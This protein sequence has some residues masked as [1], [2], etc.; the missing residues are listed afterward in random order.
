MGEKWPVS[1]QPPPTILPLAPSLFVLR[2]RTGPPSIPETEVK[3][4]HGPLDISYD[5]TLGCVMWG[6]GGGGLRRCDFYM[7][8][9]KKQTRWWERD[10]NKK[11]A[12]RKDWEAEIMRSACRSS[13]LKSIYTIHAL[14]CQVHT[15]PC[16][17]RNPS[18][19][20]PL[21]CFLPHRSPF[22]LSIIKESILTGT[23]EKMAATFGGKG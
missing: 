22:W 4:Q 15:A 16:C 6:R 8:E 21:Q 7:R 11:L 17:P 13:V 10:E 1:Q 12:F 20:Q 18:V 3:G 14:G 2:Q 9:R 19:S 5:N 23:Y